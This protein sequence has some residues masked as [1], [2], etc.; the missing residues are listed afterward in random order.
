[1]VNQFASSIKHKPFHNELDKARALAFIRALR[2]VV[3]EG[4]MERQRDDVVS[5]SVELDDVQI[6]T[7]VTGVKDA[8]DAMKRRKHGMD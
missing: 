2:L 3:S 1:M 5:D 7:N 6:E 4:T 8:R